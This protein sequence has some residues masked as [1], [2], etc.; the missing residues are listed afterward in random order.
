MNEVAPILAEHIAEIRRL[1]KRMIADIVEIGRR[2]TECQEIVGH[3]SWAAWLEVNFSWSDRTALNFMRVFELSKSEIISDFGQ[4][5]LPVTALYLLA[6]PST[7]EAVRT[8]I[9]GRAKTGDDVS[10]EDVKEAI[11]GTRAARSVNAKPLPDIADG[12]V[13][14]V[15]RRIE[16]AITEIQSRY[17]GKSRTKIERLFAALTDT[18]ADLEHKTLPPAKDDTGTSAAERKAHYAAIEDRS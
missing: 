12:C 14:A 15:H 7:P 4:V 13:A 18:L 3:G 10:V 5:D 9:L 6:A 2:L 8:E 16:D 17:K 11:A 1:G